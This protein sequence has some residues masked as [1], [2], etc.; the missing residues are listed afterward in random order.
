MDRFIDCCFNIR[1]GFRKALPILQM[2]EDMG[3]VNE[4]AAIFESV[5]SYHVGPRW[6]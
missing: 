4:S 3:W 1:D 2:F 5:G 6:L